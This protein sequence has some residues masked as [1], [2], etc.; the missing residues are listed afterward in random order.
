MSAADP[1]TPTRPDLNARFLSPPDGRASVTDRAGLGLEADERLRFRGAQRTGGEVAVT[2]RRLLVVGGGQVRSVPLENVAELTHRRIDWFQTLLGVG[3]VGFGA[4]SAGRHLAGAALFAVAGLASLAL[5]WRDRH[6]V[7]VHT[8][9][10]PKPLD[11]H[12]RDPERFLA[13]ADAA[14]DPLRGNR[15]DDDRD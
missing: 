5:T 12:P 7:R 8:H 2:D 4:V 11:S 3:L 9:S 6:R 10:R 1:A 15:R 13:A 14:L